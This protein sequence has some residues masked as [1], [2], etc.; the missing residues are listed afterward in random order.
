MTYSLNEVHALVRLFL[1]HLNEV[2]TVKEMRAKLNA[3]S[4][5]FDLDEIHAEIEANDLA[6]DLG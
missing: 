3:E 1:I 2:Y 6:N 4:V 5:I